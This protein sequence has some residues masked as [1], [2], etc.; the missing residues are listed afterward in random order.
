MRRPTHSLGVAAAAALA[1]LAGLSSLTACGSS[2]GTAGA[3]APSASGGPATASK[4]TGTVTVFAA[5]SLKEAFTTLGHRFEQA[6]PGAHVVLNLGPSSGLAT[7]ITQGAPADVFASASAK[8]MD[9]V[10]SAGAAAAPRTFARNAMEVAVPPS[11]PARVASVRDLGRPG[12]KVALCQ[13]QVP[14]GVTAATV[15]ARAGVQVHPVSQELDVKSVLAK[16]T[17]GEVDAGVV[18]V[19]DVKAAGRQVTGIPIPAAV[20]AST[21]YPI[22]TLS[23]APNKSAAQAFTDYVLSGEAAPVLAAAGFGSP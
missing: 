2:T 17:L 15:F 14:C 21:S 10:V 5:A 9:Q 6:H 12:V 19:T 13:P 16:V 7:Q 22:A 8:N 3:G 1:A 4:V 20:N 23:A 11:N 18:Y